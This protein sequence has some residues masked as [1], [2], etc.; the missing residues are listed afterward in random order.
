MVY[1]DIAE[2]S[3]NPF[4]G[5]IF[6]QPNGENVYDASTIDYSGR[7][8]SRDNFLAVLQGDSATTGGKPVLQS[9]SNSKVFVYYTD[10]GAA[11]FVCLPTGE[12]LYAF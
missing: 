6:N 8:V 2:S 1:D 7:D 12:Y 5:Q 3:S 11:G 9:N 4:K 10:H